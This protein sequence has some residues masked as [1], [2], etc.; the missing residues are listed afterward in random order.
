MLLSIMSK[1]FS[2]AKLIRETWNDYNLEIQDG[3]G[4]T[5]AKTFQSLW[6]TNPVQVLD[7]TE[8]DSSIFADMQSQAE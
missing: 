1:S 8:I 6:K 5:Q 2:L 3:C 4:Q 7:V